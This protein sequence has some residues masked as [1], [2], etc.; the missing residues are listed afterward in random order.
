MAL[1]GDVGFR[2][3]G[4]DGCRRMIILNFTAIL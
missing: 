4:A 3:A 1:A 2:H